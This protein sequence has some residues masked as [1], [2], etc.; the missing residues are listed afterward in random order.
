MTEIPQQLL[1]Q[2]TPEWQRVAIASAFII[3][4]LTIGVTE[5]IKRQFG[6]PD[7]GLPPKE[8]K[9]KVMGL[10]FCLGFA[11]SLLLMPL[12]VEGSHYEV[13]VKVLV[14]AVANGVLS[15]LGFDTIKFALKLFRAYVIEWVRAKVRKKLIEEPSRRHEDV[16][17][18][19]TVVK[20]ANGGK[21]K[22]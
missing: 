9:R 14:I 21:P 5:V 12:A 4:V 18:S 19:S 15:L 3:L 13:A 17:W 22:P 10:A 6:Y 11:W 20:W 16:D 8:W 1:T 7:D 2:F